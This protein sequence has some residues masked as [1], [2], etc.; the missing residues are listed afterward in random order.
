MPRNVG[1]C[2]AA[3]D[4]DPRTLPREGTDLPGAAQS[5]IQDDRSEV[6][7]NAAHVRAPGN[8]PEN[9]LEK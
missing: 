8:T 4:A 7:R 9:I 6:A 3:A 5:G 1:C 2:L